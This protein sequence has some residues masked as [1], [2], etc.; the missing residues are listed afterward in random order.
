[1]SDP[2]NPADWVEKA[3]E[4]YALV[5]SSLR[6]KHPLIYGATFHA[7]QCV[8]KYLKALL[9]LHQQIPPRTHDLNILVE[10]CLQTGVIVPVE[11]EELRHLTQHGVRSRYT[12]QG[13]KLS[14]FQPQ[15]SST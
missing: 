4:D 7:Q 8:E 3:E 6:R 2:T 9:I 13:H 10:L 14:F 5:L 15:K 11:H 1:M 12:A